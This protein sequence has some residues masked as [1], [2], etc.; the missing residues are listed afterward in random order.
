MIVNLCLPALQVLLH[1]RYLCVI[2]ISLGKPQG[3]FRR[4][5][6]LYMYQRVFKRYINE[7]IQK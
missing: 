6:L 3:V 5:S 2:L 1:W 4:Q 7:N